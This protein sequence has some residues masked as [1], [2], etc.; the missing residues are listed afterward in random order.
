MKKATITAILIFFVCIASAQEKRKISNFDKLIVKGSFDVRL[1]SGKDELIIRSNDA[2]L[3]KHI[4]TEVTNNT[5]TIYMEKGYRMPKNKDIDIDVPFKNLS[6]ISLSGSGS[7]VSNETI[8]S[9]NL[10]ITLIGSGDVEIKA[11]TNDLKAELSGSGDIK[12]IG[13]AVNFYASISGSGDVEAFGLIADNTEVKISGSGDAEVYAK[14]SL[15]ARVS[16]SGDIS[17]KGNPKREDS[18][19]SGSGSIK[20]N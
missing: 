18:K 11:N 15:K 2:E 19:V 16:G 5:L 12:L 10:N 14:E 7:I 6:D 20:K 17:F 9:Q 8:K 4:K 3:L 1:V 13:S